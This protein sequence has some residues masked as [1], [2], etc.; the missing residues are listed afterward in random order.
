[1]PYLHCRKGS[2]TWREGWQYLLQYRWTIP[3]FF[4]GHP[5]VVQ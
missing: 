4:E 2:K 1:M 3:R 5:G